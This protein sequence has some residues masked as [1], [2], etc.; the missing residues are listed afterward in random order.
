MKAKKKLSQKKLLNDYLRGTGRSLTPDQA[1]TGFGIK[2]L[3]ARMSELREDGLRVRTTETIFGT[4]Y[5]I[6]QRD[7]NGNRVSFY[8]PRETFE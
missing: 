3:S 7:V 5:R 2:N 4:E 8:G 1:R 6:S